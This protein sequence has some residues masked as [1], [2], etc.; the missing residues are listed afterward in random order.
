MDQ[1]RWLFRHLRINVRLFFKLFWISLRVWPYILAWY[2]TL[3]IR[4]LKQ[5]L[6][7]A[8][9]LVYLA[10]D[11]CVLLVELVFDLVALLFRVFRRVLTRVYE[12]V[13]H[14]MTYL[15]FRTFDMEKDLFDSWVLNDVGYFCAC[16]CLL[17]LFV[18]FVDLMVPLRMAFFSVVQFI[19]QPLF[20]VFWVY[21]GLF[22][23]FPKPTLFR[24]RV[25]KSIFALGF[26][27]TYEQATVVTKTI[28]FL[29]I[30]TLCCCVFMDYHS[31]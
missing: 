16:L 21:F 26:F 12:A 18:S 25:T 24:D 13:R 31:P 15:S 14:F 6:S 19:I 9:R 8:L 20:Q 17:L 7:V 28:S 29:M 1:L 5:L 23:L 10:M 4:F 27:T 2:Y 3:L 11:T 30:L 22:F